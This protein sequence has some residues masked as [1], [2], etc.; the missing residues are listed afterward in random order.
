[1][2]DHHRKSHALATL[3]IRKR[4]TS[5]YFL[6]DPELRLYGWTNLKTGEK[7]L[8]LETKLQL[9]MLAFSGIQVLNPDVF[10][11]IT[12]EGKFSLTS[13][14]LRLAKENLIRGFLDTSSVW[15]DVGKEPLNGMKNE[16]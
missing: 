11:L 9:E 16:K 13:L 15:K 3:A 5:R 8:S 12:E 7:I 10:A 2:M 6:F 4:E 14:Y 1:M